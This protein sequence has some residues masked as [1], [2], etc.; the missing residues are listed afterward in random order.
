MWFLVEM[1][2]LFFWDNVPLCGM[3]TV[4]LFLFSEL[5]SLALR[6]ILKAT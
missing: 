6:V 1:K 5:N 2:V 3:A 4:G